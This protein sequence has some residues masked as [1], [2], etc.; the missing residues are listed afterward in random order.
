MKRFNKLDISLGTAY[1]SRIASLLNLVI[2]FVTWGL[3]LCMNLLALLKHR[4][5]EA[6][7]LKV[8]LVY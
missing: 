6:G 2:L 7:S 1:T 4:R 3:R 8:K 5:A